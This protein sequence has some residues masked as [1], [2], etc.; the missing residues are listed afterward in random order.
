MQQIFEESDDDTD[1]KKKG[2]KKSKNFL[3]EIEFEHPE[4]ANYSELF[5]QFF[6]SPLII[7][8]GLGRLVVLSDRKTTV[9]NFSFA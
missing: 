2:K 9:H 6:F 7:F 3:K 1:K 8:A 5:W 4:L